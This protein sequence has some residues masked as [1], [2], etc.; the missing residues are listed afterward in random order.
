MRAFSNS[1]KVYSFCLCIV[2][3]TRTISYI[4]RDSFVSD[5]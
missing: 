5:G 2:L 1:D 4:W 3:K